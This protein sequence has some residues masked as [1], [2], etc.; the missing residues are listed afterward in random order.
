MDMMSQ[1][2]DRPTGLHETNV[3]RHMMVMMF[4]A[5]D[6]HWKQAIKFRERNKVDASK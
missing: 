3:S 1:E 5:G 6:M 4:S 2:I